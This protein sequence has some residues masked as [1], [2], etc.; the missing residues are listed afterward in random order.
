[1]ECVVSV[2]NNGILLKTANNAVSSCP[3]TA[4][5]DRPLNDYVIVVLAGWRALARYFVCAIYT[6]HIT[7]I[8]YGV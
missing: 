6:L 5:G 3:V 8:A 2:A 4:T 1:M 7:L